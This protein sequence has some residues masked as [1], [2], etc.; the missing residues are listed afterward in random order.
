MPGLQW[1]WKGL[2]SRN[3]RPLSIPYLKFPMANS[4]VWQAVS[5]ILI[6]LV[7]HKIWT[8]QRALK[9]VSHI[10]GRQ[11]LWIDPFH[12]VSLVLGS[13][14][15]WAG[16][17]G[18]YSAKFS[19]YEKY[20]STCLS[21]VRLWNSQVYYWIADADALKIVTSDRHTFQKDVQA[22]SI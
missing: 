2:H 22:V 4:T 5:A 3:T 21:T 14:F 10:P 20:G 6:V 16:R 11:F 17:I 9:C 15:P 18:H 19:L 13:T 7:V 1:I 12:A 8:L